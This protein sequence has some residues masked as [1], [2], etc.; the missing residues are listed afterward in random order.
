M[1]LIGIVTGFNPLQRWWYHTPNDQPQKSCVQ[2][3]SVTT[4][5]NLTPAKLQQYMLCKIIV[6]PPAVTG[7]IHEATYMMFTHSLHLNMFN[8][9]SD[10]PARWTACKLKWQATPHM[11][12][13]RPAGRMRPSTS[14]DPALIHFSGLTHIKLNL[15]C[16]HPVARVISDDVGFN[17]STQRHYRRLIYYVYIYSYMFRSYDHHQTE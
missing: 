4:C 12:N 3:T 13:R 10:I 1:R 16:L 17:P 9:T 11:C 14:Y 6:R 15:G 7:Q 2:M 5:Y 8:Y